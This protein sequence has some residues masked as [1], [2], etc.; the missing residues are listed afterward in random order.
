MGNGKNSLPCV[1]FITLFLVCCRPL[2]G[3]C[4][5]WRV[6]GEVGLERSSFK[7]TLL[8]RSL[9]MR[10]YQ[11]VSLRVHLTSWSV[12]LL[13]LSPPPLHPSLLPFLLSTPPPLH[14]ASCPV[15]HCWVP[16]ELGGRTGRA[17]AGPRSGGPGV[18]RPQCH[19]A[20]TTC[21]AP[22]HLRGTGAVCHMCY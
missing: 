21:P 10:W 22:V 5:L 2:S 3:D 17:G 15:Q 13:P 7:H 20:L 6:M 18:V 11:E 14:P 4:V 1:F 16:A 9:F 8:H 12:C 19:A